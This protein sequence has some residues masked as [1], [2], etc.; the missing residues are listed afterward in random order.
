MDHEY[1]DEMECY[2]KLQK[3]RKEQLVDNI[4]FLSHEIALQLKELELKKEQ[5][6][7]VVK[8]IRIAKKH[9]SD[10]IAVK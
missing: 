10:H 9:L 8:S 5:L 3:L 2:I 6:P 7:L 4:E 1:V